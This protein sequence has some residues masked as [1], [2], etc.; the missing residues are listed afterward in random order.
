MPMNVQLLQEVFELDQAFEIV[1]EGL[2]RME[3]VY[4]LQATMVREDHTKVVLT[5]IDFNRLFVGDFQKDYESDEKWAADFQ[6]ACLA[7]RAIPKTTTLECDNGRKHERRR[8]S[9]RE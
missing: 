2:M 1:I 7:K 3:K 8:G 5:R 9:R 6:R 4:F